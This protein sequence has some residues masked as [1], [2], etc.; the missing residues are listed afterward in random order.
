VSGARPRR[1]RGR[2][3]LLTVAVILVAALGAV[4]APSG[5]APKASKCHGAAARDPKHPCFNPTRSVSPTLAHAA[6]E[7]GSRCALTTQK[8]EPICRFGT[9]AASATDHVAL[10]GD[11]HALHWRAAL[12]VVA[13]HERWQAYSITVPGCLFST[14]VDV[15]FEGAREP[16]VAWFRAA[17]R[18]L[19]H[20]HEIHTVFVSQ[21]S[22]TP[23][24]L[25]P[26]ENMI[27]RKVEGFRRAWSALPKSVTRLVVIR[28][29]PTS[30]ATALACLKRVIA[31][32]TQRP[33]PTCAFAR[34]AAIRKDAAVATILRLR[35]KR[36]R[37][38][39]LTRF[40][41]AARLCYPVIG[42]TLVFRDIYGHMTREYSQS[43][44]PYL[45]RRV[46][47]AT[48]RSDG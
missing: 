46:R 9:P 29:T 6:D 38:V 24:V 33:G 11:S 32:H 22:D 5:A 39:D 16:C 30:N 48:R 47:R 12:D 43:L 26:G 35:S 8:P 37:Y 36:F 42:G 15:M 44:G 34:S 3:P 2:R 4:A 25:K 10:I 45:L 40:F 1:T 28:D 41:C 17:R 7:L 23:I 19:A 18:W 14:A 27:D 31:A 20:H 21:N 13:R